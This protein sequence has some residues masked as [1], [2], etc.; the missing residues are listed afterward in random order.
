MDKTLLEEIQENYKNPKPKKVV[1]TEKPKKANP[2]PRRRW[3]W[4][5]LGL[6]TIVFLVEGGV[7]LWSINLWS[8]FHNVGLRLPVEFYAPLTITKIEQPFNNQHFSTKSTKNPS[9]LDKVGLIYGA[10][11]GEIVAKVWK[12][13]ST[14]GKAERGHHQFCNDLEKTNEFGFFKNGNRFH[15]FDSFE[16]SVQDVT[17]WFKSNL[18]EL[19]LPVALCYYNTGNLQSDCKYWQDYKKL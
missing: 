16:E 6:A 4:L 19:P 8:K 10:G 1:E 17:N 14:G 7:L 11:L 15:C 12:L 18:E 5:S 2:N 13:E 9:E 3:V